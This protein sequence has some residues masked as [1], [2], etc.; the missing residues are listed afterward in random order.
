M[1]HTRASRAKPR[2]GQPGLSS[3]PIQS[4]DA[5]SPGALAAW[6]PRVCAKLIDTLV[7]A[8]PSFLFYFL[9][10]LLDAGAWISTVV[11]MTGW[12]W[13]IYDM[14]T[15]GQSIGKRW[16]DIRL[17]SERTGQP[18][19]FGKAIVYEVAQI[20]DALPLG[21]GYLWPLIDKKQQTFSDKLLHTLAVRA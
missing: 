17:V 7:V 8:V 20:L 13:V 12:L 6:G 5:G 16:M 1:D 2:D 19:G 18:V 21:V 9:G 14:G 3:P 11:S 4:D 10:E 15:T